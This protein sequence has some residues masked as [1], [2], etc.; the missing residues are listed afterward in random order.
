MIVV[1]TMKSFR[2]MQKKEEKREE[3]FFR[4][5]SAWMSALIQILTMDMALA[6]E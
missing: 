5:L 2:I 3:W 1:K 6:N 4:S